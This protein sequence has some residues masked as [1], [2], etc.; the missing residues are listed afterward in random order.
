MA[1]ALGNDLLPDALSIGAEAASFASQYRASHVVGPI[2]GLAA[3]GY[4]MGQ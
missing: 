4:P 2:N 3:D 1:N